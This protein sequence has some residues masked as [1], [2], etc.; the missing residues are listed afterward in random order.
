MKPKPSKFTEN[1]CGVDMFER[2]RFKGAENVPL[3]SGRK[4]RRRSVES[5]K[6]SNNL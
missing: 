5:G 1:Y 3:L 4:S 6:G 2:S